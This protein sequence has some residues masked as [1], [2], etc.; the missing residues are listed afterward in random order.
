VWRNTGEERTFALASRLDETEVR[1]QYRVDV[2]NRLD[3][4][5]YLQL[6]KLELLD[7]DRLSLGS[8]AD[9]VK[10][11]LGPGKTEALLQGSVW[12]TKRSAAKVTGFRVYHFGV[13][14]SDRGRAM[15]REWLLQGR[16]EEG[17]A[18]DA[19][20]ARYASAPPCS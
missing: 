14:L 9:E 12:V 19:E 20:L 17:A 5:L 11:T 4:K 15:Y 16:P 2:H 6:G 3:A 8:A 7:D 18:I 13:P 10:C 1:F